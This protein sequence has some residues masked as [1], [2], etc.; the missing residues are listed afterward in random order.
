M[1]HADA[2]EAF[3]LIG[4]LTDRLTRRQLFQLRGQ[5]A[6]GVTQRRGQF[7]TASE[8]TVEQAF[9]D[10]VQFRGQARDGHD[11]GKMGAA[12]EGMQIALQGA[13]V[14]AL[15]RFD[16]PAL[17]RPI[18]AVQQVLGLFEEDQLHFRIDRIDGR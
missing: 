3:D 16:Q 4:M 2:L 15:L 1:P 13:E 6:M 8:T 7:G 14:K 17:Q 12:L 9:V 11:P 5:A 18:G 10:G